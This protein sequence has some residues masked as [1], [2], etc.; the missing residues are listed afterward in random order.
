MD[1]RSLRRTNVQKCDQTVPEF[2]HPRVDF[3]LA[4][5][6][7]AITAHFQ[8]VELHDREVGL[9]FKNGNITGVLAP[10]KENFCWRD[11]I[12]VSVVG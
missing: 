2:E 8:V 9:V 5:A 7:A 3:L 6:G 4:A 10:G 1:L 12:K 11:P